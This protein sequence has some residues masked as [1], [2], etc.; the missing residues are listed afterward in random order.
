M[1]PE[2]SSRGNLVRDFDDSLLSQMYLY[3]NG[4]LI[5]ICGDFSGIV[6]SLKDFDDMID[7]DCLPE[8]EIVDEIKKKLG[9]TW[10][11]F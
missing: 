7:L 1:Q 8:R 11:L 9:N 3:S 2:Q 10:F 4:N 5:F 6:G